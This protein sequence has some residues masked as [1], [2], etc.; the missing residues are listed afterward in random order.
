MST[1][2]PQEVQKVL[3]A[4]QKDDRQHKLEVVLQ[5]SKENSS[6]AHPIYK[7]SHEPLVPNVRNGTKPVNI[8]SLVPIRMDTDPKKAI[9]NL[10]S[11]EGSGDELDESEETKEEKEDGEED[12]DEKRAGG[13]RVQA[14]ED[15]EET[16]NRKKSKSKKADKT[17][18][19]K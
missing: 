5:K 6:I 1:F 12:A 13:K 4:T 3:E 7:N 2:Y 8:T 9:A 18:S 17:K 16:P 15:K 10:A 14:N 11:A 19:K